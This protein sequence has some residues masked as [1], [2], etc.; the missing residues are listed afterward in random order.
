MKALL[1]KNYKNLEYVDFPT[2]EIGP[3]DV[4]VQ[5]KAVG[6]CGSDIHGYDGSTGY[7]RMNRSFS[8]LRPVLPEFMLAGALIFWAAALSLV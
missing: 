1:L 3:N 6:I 5:V 8:H 7:V 4:L 2:P